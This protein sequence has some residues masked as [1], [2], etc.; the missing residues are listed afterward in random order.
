MARE[1]GEEN[2]FLFGLTADQVVESRLS[3]DPKWHYEHEPETRDALDL[4]LTDYFS[5]QEPGVFQPIRE[6]LLERGDYYMHL[7]DLTSYA[8]AQTRVAA[9][10]ESP[11][12]WA[13]MAI[14]NVASSG[15][16]SS[17]RTITEYAADIWN[18]RPSPVP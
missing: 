2:I 5:R 3:Y 6:A 1:V 16:F 11:A 7:A 8:N 13:R 4:I 9:L 17:D 14:L 10:R 15:R 18:A 12:A